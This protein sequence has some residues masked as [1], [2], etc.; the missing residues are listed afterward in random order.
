M[1]GYL[2][3]PLQPCQSASGYS[4]VIFIKLAEATS[5]LVQR[6]A[7]LFVIL[8]ELL[9]DELLTFKLIHSECLLPPDNRWRLRPLNGYWHRI[10]GNKATNWLLTCTDCIHEHLCVITDLLVIF[11][12]QDTIARI[13][14]QLTI[15]RSC[16]LCVPV[17][18]TCMTSAGHN[19]PRTISYDPR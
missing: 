12:L 7:Y 19:L 17:R 10:G 9:Y 14:N 3:S 6:K 13:S 11:H 8:H 2:E 15:A 5:T 1:H 16:N 18:H 4:F